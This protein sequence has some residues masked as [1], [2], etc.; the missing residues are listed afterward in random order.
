MP[1][2]CPNLSIHL[3]HVH[4][5]LKF[6]NMLIIHILLEYAIYVLIVLILLCLVAWCW[7]ISLNELNIHDSHFISYDMCSFTTYPWFNVL[8]LITLEYYLHVKKRC[9]L[10]LWDIWIIWMTV[11]FYCWSIISMFVCY[12]VDT[13][14]HL[15]HKFIISLLEYLMLAMKFSFS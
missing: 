9:I 3:E 12:W 7:I 10:L 2:L 4:F 11:M 15:G 1:L 6:L 8:G 13:N 5:L 14:L